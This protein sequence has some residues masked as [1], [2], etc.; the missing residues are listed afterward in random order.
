MHFFLR[1]RIGDSFE[2]YIENYIE[3][4]IEG[5]IFK[6]IKVVKIVYLR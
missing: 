4:Y 6:D 5:F 1:I 3:G 2:G